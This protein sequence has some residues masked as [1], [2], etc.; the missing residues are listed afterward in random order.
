MASTPRIA[1]AVLASSLLLLVAACERPTLPAEAAARPPVPSSGRIAVAASPSGI[2]SLLDVRGPMKF[3]DY[4][5]NEAGAAAGPLTIRVDLE[6]QLISVFRGGDE[7]GTA[8]VLFGAEGKETPRGDF[9]IRQKAADYYSHTYDA[10]MPY[11]L[12]LT[13]DGVAIHASNVREGWATHGC[14]G[15][16]MG[17]A[18][19]LFDAARLGDK[20]SIS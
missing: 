11:M 16:P 12:R 2:T 9:P 20:V 17:F 8:V 6:R 19:K 5:W 15:V 10:P 13:D 4:V 7:I 18:R 14:V 1:K 3:G